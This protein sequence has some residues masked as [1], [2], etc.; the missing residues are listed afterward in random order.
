MIGWAPSQSFERKHP[1]LTPAE[2]GR[3]W[4]RHGCGNLPEKG[5]PPTRRG[6]V[7][8]FHWCPGHRGCRV[9]ALITAWWRNALASSR[10]R[11]EKRGRVLP[12]PAARFVPTLP[13]AA[14]E[15]R[16]PVAAKVLV[17]VFGALSQLAQPPFPPVRCKES[18]RRAKP[19]QW[20]QNTGFRGFARVRPIFNRAKGVT[21]PAPNRRPG[22]RLTP[23]VAP[24]RQGVSAK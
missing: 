24:F 19:W 9:T 23:A 1:P 16:H 22:S 3:P 7:G 5:R 2:A 14:Q 8:G 21:G 17:A 12:L 15:R 20:L 11:R 10:Q 13:R 6:R 18:N 4:G